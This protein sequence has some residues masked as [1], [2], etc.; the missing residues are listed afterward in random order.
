M[1]KEEDV[2]AHVQSEQALPDHVEHSAFATPLRPKIRS[3]DIRPDM[4]QSRADGES[5]V[6]G[7]KGIRQGTEL[8]R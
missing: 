7:V 8:G 1:S 3:C 2:V 6:V 5:S 4:G